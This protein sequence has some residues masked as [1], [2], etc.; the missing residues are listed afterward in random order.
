MMQ[1]RHAAAARHWCLR[2]G[3]VR[4][5]RLASGLVLLACVSLHLTD[6]ALANVSVAASDAM[7]GV[8]KTLWQS[9]AGVALLYG[10]ISIHV[11]L[12]W[13]LYERRHFRWTRTEIVQL[14]SGFC[15]PLLLANHILVTRV[16]RAASAPTK[17]T[18]SSFTRFESETPSLVSCSIWRWWWHGC[19]GCYF[20]CG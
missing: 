3:S 15:I 18:L 19:I 13:A 11:L 17:I 6:H 16:S 4:A 1:K 2:F 7:L 20:G 5:L 8:M 14:V 9:T 10:A 12:Y